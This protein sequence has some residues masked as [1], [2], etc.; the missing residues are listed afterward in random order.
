MLRPPQAL[1]AAI[2][3]A[4]FL[5]SSA[6]PTSRPA[7]LVIYGRVWTGDS[8]RPWARAVAISGSKIAQVGDSATVARMIGPATKVLGDGKGMVVP[9]FMDGHVHLLSAGFQ[10]ARIQ[11][12]DVNTPREFILRLKQHAA[13][14]KPGEWITGGDW[15]HERWPGA[16]LPER[17]WIDS[18][19]PNNPVFVNRVDGHMSLANS[20]ALRLAH[21]S[22]MTSDVPGGTIVRD[23]RT[24]EPTGALKDNA[25]DLVERVRP[26]PSPAQSDSALARA[27]RWAA[28]RGVTSVATMAD[29][30]GTLAIGPSW[31][32]LATLKR[33]HRRG[34]MLTRVTI[35]VSLEA[36]RGMADSLRADGPGDD[37]LRSAGV[38]G[39]VD[40]SLGSRT[41]LFYEDYDDAPGTRGLFVTLEDSLRAWIGGADSA[42]LQVAV[43]AIGE[44]AN[45]VLLS[46]YD[47]VARAHGD[48]DRRFRIEHAQHLRQQDIGRLARSGVIASMQPYHA[49]DD[50]RWAEKRIGPERIKTTYAF[51]SL[52][53]DRAHLGFGSDWTVAPLDPILGIYAAVTRRTLDGKNPAGWVPEQKITVEEALRAYTSANA[54][55]VFAERSRGKL[56]PGYLA[57]LVVLDQDLTAI[58]PADIEKAQVLATV[59]G[60]RLVF[61][62]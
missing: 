45:G 43:H 51:R 2:G 10:L 50:G 31:R 60:G 37:W 24:G 41:A 58:S 28:A 42:G 40:G 32:E 35:Y 34:S 57:D 25:R 36:W 62:R 59:V 13:T 3:L 21:V 49:I 61:Q 9:G 48:R 27:M 22:R 55:G 19:T 18:V 5:G 20:A 26:I 44:R 52:L 54:Y 12:R 33:A 30:P 8:S 46:I 56:V 7:D 23:P 15:D 38:K 14:L 39:F 17:S 47:S 6:V 53:D 29:D 11:L 1:W 16:P 4:G